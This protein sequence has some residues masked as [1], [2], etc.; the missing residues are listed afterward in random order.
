MILIVE[1]AD[2]CHRLGLIDS[3]EATVDVSTEVD[4]TFSV[5]VDKYEKDEEQWEEQVCSY[6][7]EQKDPVGDPGKMV[8]YL[9]DL[10]AKRKAI[11]LSEL[12]I[13]EE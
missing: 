2:K 10:I 5:R 11:L 13:V 8:E 7:K 3:Y 9:Q 1:L 4:Y 6:L 12:E